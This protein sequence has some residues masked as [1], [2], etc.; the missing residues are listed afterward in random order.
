MFRIPAIKFKKEPLS[1]KRF[2]DMAVILLL[3]WI[4]VELL[5]MYRGQKG[6]SPGG[7]DAA[8]VARNISEGR[9][10]TTNFVHPLSFGFHQSISSHPELYQPPLF[11]IVV[12]FA[13]AL[14]GKVSERVVISCCEV[15]FLLTLLLLYEF[16]CRLYG[17]KVG[18]M[19]AFLYLVSGEAL[20][21][22]SFGNPMLLTS[23]L[24]T[25]WF[26]LTCLGS[27]KAHTKVRDFGY[28]I[29]SAFVFSLAVLS[30]YALVFAFP[31]VLWLNKG[32]RHR[33]ER[34]PS[35]SGKGESY[36]R[37]FST[38]PLFLFC[39]GFVIPLS[40]GMFRNYRLTGNPLFT[41][42][43]YDFLVD[44]QSYP[45]DT[46][47]R[48]I[49]PSVLNPLSL[50]A[51]HSLEI[52]KK[53]FSNLK[54]LFGFFHHWGLAVTLFSIVA[55]VR[56]ATVP[57]ERLSRFYAAVLLSLLFIA[58]LTVL[59][60]SALLPLLP[61]AC[62]LAG[63]V[64]VEIGTE[65][66][67]WINR[68]MEDGWLPIHRVKAFFPFFALVALSLTSS[69]LPSIQLHSNKRYTS[70]ERA[71]G[72]LYFQPS[73]L[74]THSQRAQGAAATHSPSIASDAPLSLAWKFN[75]P[76][77]WLPSKKEEWEILNALNPIEEVWLAVA[78]HERPKE[79]ESG[80]GSEEKIFFDADF[81]LFNNKSEIPPLTKP[82]ADR[83]RVLSGGRGDFVVFK[84]TSLA[85]FPLRSK[86][87]PSSVFSS[88]GVAEI[89]RP[90]GTRRETQGKTSVGFRLAVTYLQEGRISD[91]KRVLR[92]V[93]SESPCN[94]AAL[95]LYGNILL[96]EG[97][98]EA[99]VHIFQQWAECKPEEPLAYQLMGK[100][101]ML[102][103]NVV[104]AKESFQNLLTLQPDNLSAQLGLGECELAMG[105]EG[106]AF[107]IFQKL[108]QENPNHPGASLSIAKCSIKSGRWREALKEVQPLL[109]K[110]SSG[111]AKGTAPLF[112][113]AAEAILQ[114]GPSQRQQAEKYLFKA[115]EAT[116]D[117]ST[118]QAVGDVYLKMG[119]YEKAILAF[120]KAVALQP[121]GN[122]GTENFFRLGMAYYEQ[123]RPED[124]VRAYQGALSCEKEN[125]MA[126]NNL[127]WTHI[128]RGEMDSAL[129]WSRYALKRRPSF[130]LILD[131][132]GW[133][134]YKMGRYRQAVEKLKKAAKA[135]QNK[136]SIIY[137]LGMAYKKR[138]KTKEAEKLLKAV[139]G[140]REIR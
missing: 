104:L 107:K 2:L 60:F 92:N 73:S 77:I 129:F 86:E 43:L 65:V 21:G 134:D 74:P 6:L 12:G 140:L 11:P 5:L 93:L 30:H 19:G 10:F 76:V 59:N 70:R 8:Q 40:I 106:A 56:P 117:V 9:G 13:F 37:I 75:S 24:L 108:K 63:V 91:A 69:I 124:A 23:F 53:G 133:T 82:Q 102:V 39:I 31:I 78:S 87:R 34:S 105:D 27:A 127:A 88:I 49:S 121:T 55:I 3:G 26:F 66:A 33:S 97:E 114:E 137:H 122:K 110:Q 95:Y 45:G 51:T 83:R 14:S 7:L 115:L 57:F 28:P 79:N 25:F 52:I 61:V 131:T 94:E 84:R 80:G 62:L 29:L 20:L 16:G 128:E 111:E 136:P 38:L 85:S 116:E 35:R 36:Y 101:Q 54:S 125:F 58:C 103:G 119:N 50:I 4:L 72:T 109:D 68:S 98:K 17:R 71:S 89:P 15:F 120:K 67:E 32:E 96:E 46:I 130:P 138:G 123:G 81:Q 99:A 44:T 42:K 132:A 64:V 118:A 139:N 90:E 135:S 126:A 41:L 18:A 112:L 48:S 22:V 1:R 47:F 100:A 113:V